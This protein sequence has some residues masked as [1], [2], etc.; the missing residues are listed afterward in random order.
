MNGLGASRQRELSYWRAYG[1]GEA[2]PL[3]AFILQSFLTMT[4]P[5][6]FSGGIGDRV[7][8]HS[9]LL[10]WKLGREESRELQFGR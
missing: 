7:G 4:L 9:A 1:K 3:V 10:S 2:A 6:V 8:G 5:E